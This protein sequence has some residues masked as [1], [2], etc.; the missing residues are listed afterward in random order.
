MLEWPPYSPDLNPIE[1][2]WRILKKTV[3]V[4]N[5]GLDLVM[6]GDDAVKDAFSKALVEAWQLIPQ[7]YFDAVIE[8]MP[9]RMEA[10]VASEGW[11]TKY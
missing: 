8:S 7:R 2:L 6:G 1:N 9:R 5:P 4:V 3:Y 10:V 11:H